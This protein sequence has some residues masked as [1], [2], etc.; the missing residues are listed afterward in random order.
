MS[1]NGTETDVDV[2]TESAGSDRIAQRFWRP[3]GTQRALQIVL[4]LFWV[5]D[6]ALQFQPF[7]FKREFVETFILPN[8]SGQPAVISW[9]ITNIGHFIEPH[10]ALW[11][12]FFALIQVVIGV[13]LLF[14]Q[15][16]RPALGLSFAWVL[17]V[18]VLGEGLGMI[19]TG[20]A[21]ALSGAPGSVLIYGLIGLMAWPTNRSDDSAVGVDSSASAFGLGGR[22]TPLVVWSGYWSLAA[23]LFLL[24]QN[25]ARGSISGMITDMASGNPS[26]FDHFL[27]SLGSGLSSVGNAGGWLLAIVSLIIGFGPLLSRRPGIFLVAGGVLAF[28]MWVVAQGWIGGIFSGSGTDPNTGPL[29][30]VL[31]LAM[32]PAFVAAPYVERTPLVEAGRRH[33]AWIGLGLSAVVL[34]LFLSALYPVAPAQSSDSAMSGTSG[35]TGMTMSG[36]TTA[37]A[38]TASCTGTNHSGL[39]VTNS[40][41]MTMAGP[42]TTMNMNGAD[43]SATAGLNSVK[44][45]W[46]YT[47]PALSGGGVPASAGR[48]RKRSG[49]DPHGQV[50]LRQ[51]ADLLRADRRHAVRSSYEPGSGPVLHGG[52]GASRWLRTGQSDE[53][54]DRLLRE[55][56]NC[57]S[58]SILRTHPRSR[59]CRWPRLRHDTFGRAG[60]RRCDVSATRNVH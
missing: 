10:I 48:G 55:P 3:I 5:L 54:P 27:N 47:G 16:V 6:A 17:G 26:W 43:A 32:T 8:A 44:E 12:T 35:M 4:G 45:N 15:T 42:G 39:D 52:G 30:I 21:S 31:A 25:R 46:H 50:G 57:D 19:L 41:L 22:V 20:T 59:C 33:G 36:S 1:E 37:D 23:V 11:N 14:P 28:A 53:L 60:S 29:I 18:W 24:P 13:G 9:V 2:A 34:A 56:D 58:Q 51:G 7:M 49:Q 40:P 38:S